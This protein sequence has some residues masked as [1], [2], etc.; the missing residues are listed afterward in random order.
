MVPHQMSRGKEAVIFSALRIQYSLQLP[1]FL[2]P[3]MKAAATTFTGQLS[4][5]YFYFKQC[6]VEVIQT[7]LWDAL[8]NQCN[9][10]LLLFDLNSQWQ[11]KGRA[12]LTSLFWYLSAH[13]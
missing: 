12:H 1:G 5:K 13:R 6:T 8:L 11:E 10:L 2:L 4:V 3:V 7:V 9:R